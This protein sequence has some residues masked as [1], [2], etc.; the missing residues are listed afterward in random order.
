MCGIVGII[1][2]YQS[3]DVSTINRMI[4]SINHR[5]PDDSGY[6][7]DE[8]KQIFLGH[9]RL[10]ILDLNDTGSQPFISNSK[11]FVLVF[12]GE[13]YNHQE[14]RENLNQSFGSIFWKGKSDTEVLINSIELLGLEKTLKIIKGMFAFALLDIK[15]NKLYL[16]RDIVGEKP[17]YYGINNNRFYFGSDLISFETDSNFQRNINK[18]ILNS[19]F[20]YNYIKTPSSIYKNIFKLEPGTV[21]TLDLNNKNNLLENKKIVKFWKNQKIKNTTNFK[22]FSDY[23][24]NLKK[25]LKNSVEKQLLSSDIETS[26]MLSSGID[27]SLVTSIASKIKNNLVTYTIGFNSSNYDESKHAEKISDFLKT[28]N[29][30]FIMTSKDA[31]N[32]SQILHKSYSEPFSDSSQLATLFLTSKIADNHKVVLTGDGGDEL[33]GGY[34]RYTQFNKIKNFYKLLQF[35]KKNYLKKLINKIHEYNFL[36]RTKGLRIL[37]RIIDADKISQ[38]FDDFFDNLI[39][40]KSANLYENYYDKSLNTKSNDYEINNATDLMNKDFENYL[41]DDLLVKMDRACMFHS[42]E[43]RSPFL[44]KDLIEFSN[45]IPF[46]YKVKNNKGKYILREILKDYIPDNLVNNTKKGF[47]VPLKQWLSGDLHEWASELLN[48]NKLKNIEGFNIKKINNIW[49]NLEFAS[50][51]EIYSIWDVIVFQN[52]YY[53][54]N[55]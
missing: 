25:I 13:I 6:F 31:F 37:K 41:P 27:S 22:D 18:D 3:I 33:F 4:K 9:T 39:S 40:H 30:K 49:N 36:K 12:N 55:V 2:K 21:L 8:K 24:N 38:N 32:M 15:I 46:Q 47:I 44:D 19:F 51:E 17:L 20:K 5:G 43:N 48:T 34:D 53:R 1:D 50:V 52:W 26:V 7:L 35:D 28:K 42:I 10:S 54:S 16:I 14:I 29:T 23:K 11:K 45:L